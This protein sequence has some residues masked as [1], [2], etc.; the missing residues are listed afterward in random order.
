MNIK[1]SSLSSPLKEF[2]NQVL[3]AKKGKQSKFHGVQNDDLE[4]ENELINT[5]FIVRIYPCVR[6]QNTTLIQ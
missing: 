2:N 1:S 4:D 5:R 3:I 6:D